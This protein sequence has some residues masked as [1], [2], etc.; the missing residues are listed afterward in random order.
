MRQ[1]KWQKQSE[2]VMLMLAEDVN[3]NVCLSKQH[4]KEANAKFKTKVYF[5]LH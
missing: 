5:F 4:G 1:M 3:R 2:S